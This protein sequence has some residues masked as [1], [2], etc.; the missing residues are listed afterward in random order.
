VSASLGEPDQGKETVPSER[1]SRA[2]WTWGAIAV[3]LGA[4]V[5]T[6]VASSAQEDDPTERREQVREQ[7]SQLDLQIDVLEADAAEIDQAMAD[8]ERNVATQQAEL[9]EA[10]RA[11]S[12]AEE[13]VRE[14][15]EA[16]AA[17]EQRITDLEAATDAMVVEAFV[18]PPGATALEAFNTDSMSDATVAQA[19]LALQADADADLLDQLG[20]AHEDLEVEEA[21]KEEAAT[22][23]AEL[24]DAAQTELTDLQGALSQQQTFA[25]EVEA[26]IESALAEA[27]ALEAV[28]AEL[29]RQIA[30]EQAEAA[31]RL[32]EM[33]EAQAAAERAAGAAPSGGGGGGGGGGGTVQPA[34][35]GL[36]TASCPGGG[37]ITVAGSIANNVQALLNLAGQ[38]GVS[39]C[40]SGWRDPQRQ[41][42][43][44]REHC[45]PTEYDIWQKPSS[46]CSPPTARPGRS[47]H[48]QGL[49]I[50]FTCNGGGAIVRGNECWNFLSA[51]ANDHGLY[52]LPSEAWHWSDNGN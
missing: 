29:S 16:V 4:A 8:L 21:A 49:A 17:A 52:N 11:H 2:P 42:E 47:R 40:G 32:R 22:E 15:E 51:N 20:A 46:Q 13:D 43:L 31:R 25:D 12:A 35:G 1:R 19:L 50:D 6:P 34:P 18:S 45:G 7:R 30:A 23:A 44:R 41:I 5:L 9:A 48:E 27:E 10:E 3:T 24:R 14:A 33:Q 37:S 26:R 36:A 39:I 28:D 38:Q